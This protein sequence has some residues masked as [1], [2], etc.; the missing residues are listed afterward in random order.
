MSAIFGEKLIF[1]QHNGSDIELRVFGDEFYA[2]Y[3]T[4]SGYTVVYDLD[5]GQYCY[6]AL[7]NGCFISSGAPIAKPVPYGIRRHLREAREI[8]NSRFKNRFNALRP[9]ET[10]IGASSNVMRTLGRNSGLLTGRQVAHGEV[11]GLTILVEFQDVRTNI[12]KDDV[13][14][15]LNGENYTQGGNYCSVRQYYQLMSSGK[16]QYT[17]TV[18]GPV[19]LSRR[20]SHYIN[21]LLVREALEIAI[22]D[23]NLDLS[24]FDSL[25]E[26][27]VDA[28]SFMYAGRTLYVGDLWPHN[29]V[30]DITDGNCR[31]HFYTI[32]SM[33][34]NRI[35]LSIGTFAHE[36]GH[37]LCRFPDLYDYGERD[38]DFE[39][40]SGLGKYCLMSS[41]DHLNGGKTPSPV[42][43]YLRDLAGWCDK[44]VNL[45]NS[46]TYDAKQADYRTLLR[47]RT[48]K[49]HEYFLVEN[50][51]QEGLDKHLPDSGLAVY[52]CDTRGSNEY[53]D[54]TP[55]KHYQCGLIQA[56]GRFDLE[57]TIQDGDDGDLFESVDGVALADDTMPDSKEWDG[58]DS[59]LVIS[60]IGAS[61]STIGFSIGRKIDENVVSR[62]TIADLIIPDKDPKGIRS[63]IPITQAG[64][65]MS[66]EVNVEISHTYRGDLKVSL[67]APGGETV[68]LHS[69]KGGDLNNLSLNLNSDSFAPLAELKGKPIEGDWTLHVSDLLKDDVG[70]LD[71][72][73][74]TIVYESVDQLAK[75]E[76]SPGAA[77]P[78]ADAGGVQSFISI[79]ETGIVKRLSVE[80]DI[81]HP[82]RGDLQ[83]ELI[84]PSGQRALLRSSTGDSRNNIHEIYDKESTPS[85][86]SI[87]G[88]QVEGDW[89]L[90]V[91]DLAARDVG[92]LD[93]WAVMIWL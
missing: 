68:V 35:D 53:Q 1:G 26:G 5:R 92:I 80:V 13:D 11:R 20:Q 89:G 27:F 70:R 67:E 62:S 46:G 34:R 14:A 30:I 12:T 64:K 10:T 8:R 84:S 81:T 38:G 22:N 69:K 4:I 75:G 50:R 83:I 85:L 33:G 73:G 24:D 43:M 19:R 55:D 72:W 76:V 93:R 86:K 56:D 45:N 54:G 18:V 87:A 3:E 78:D 16:L 39:Q 29:F 48:D 31:T 9:P 71:S 15:L 52:H 32:Q 40:S 49:P 82:Y 60:E 59:G 28:L 23:Y 57:R 37:M 77:I 90:Q 91:R 42:C 21:N 88:E 63:C 7:E 51:H 44:E 74:V 25:N 2:R 6:A 41:G 61:A 58:T 65:L 47:F 36:N 79:A 17:N 66:L